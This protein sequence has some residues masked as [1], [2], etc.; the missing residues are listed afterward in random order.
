M[1]RKIYTSPIIE[2][3]ELC[4]ESLLQQLTGAKVNSAAI[5]YGVSSTM[6]VDNNANSSTGLVQEAKHG[7]IDWD[8]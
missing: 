5:D 6:G 2:I 3:T 8:F 4:I 7:S 1:K